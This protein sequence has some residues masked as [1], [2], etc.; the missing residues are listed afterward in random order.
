M[1][2]D[3]FLAVLDELSLDL[4]QRFLANFRHEIPMSPNGSIDIDSVVD[5][6]YR[7]ENP[8]AWGGSG[9]LFHFSLHVLYNLFDG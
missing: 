3:A 5:W 4:H 2:V 1:S 6:I 7:V 8:V 9:M